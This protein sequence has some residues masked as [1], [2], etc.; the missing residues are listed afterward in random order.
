[1]SFV[2]KAL[3]VTGLPVRPTTKKNRY[4]KQAVAELRVQTALMLQQQPAVH[5]PTGQP[6]TL[7]PTH[8]GREIVTDVVALARR[9]RRIVR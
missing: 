6:V 3:I 5:R 4:A 9:V 1:M 2:K 8:T 7:V